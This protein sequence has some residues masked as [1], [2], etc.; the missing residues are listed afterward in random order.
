VAEALGCQVDIKLER[1]TPAVINDP[2]IAAKIHAA[3]EQ[4]PGLEITDQFRSMVSEDM[5]FMMEKVAGCY[6]MV[7]S[8][9]A[10]KGLNYSHHHPKFDFDESALPNAAAVMVTAAMEMLK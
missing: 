7:G 4:L 10:E 9:N 1:L 2:E 8:A 6:M 3:V 5:A